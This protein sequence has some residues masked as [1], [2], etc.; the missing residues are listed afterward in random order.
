VFVS[1]SMRL[2]TEITCW[3]RDSRKKYINFSLI[4]LKQS[5]RLLFSDIGLYHV[6]KVEGNGAA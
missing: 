1:K 6:R 4:Y 2:P 3:N 5:L